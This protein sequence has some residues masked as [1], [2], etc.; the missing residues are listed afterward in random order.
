METKIKHTLKR[1]ESSLLNFGKIDQWKINEDF[2]VLGHYISNEKPSTLKNVIRDCRDHAIS[3][4]VNISFLLSRVQ[5]AQGILDGIQA[6]DSDKAVRKNNT[7]G[8]GKR[9]ASTTRKLYKEKL[10]FKNGE[11]LSGIDI[12]LEDGKTTRKVRRIVEKRMCQ[13]YYKLNKTSA[14]SNCG[15]HYSKRATSYQLHNLGNIE[16]ESGMCRTDSTHWKKV[17]DSISGCQV[18]KQK[19]AYSSY[20]E[21]CEAARLFAIK[22]PNK[23]PVNAYKCIYCDKWHI[24]H[25]TPEEEKVFTTGVT[26]L[27][28]VS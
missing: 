17:Y 13:A 16:Y 27:E 25:T 24:G 26:F 4:S 28:N 2:A 6:T 15:R 9:F 3:E 8:Q 18:Y 23:Y 5:T 20:E 1:W 11:N 10:K 14:E 7:T 21:A 12:S 22:Y 19:Q